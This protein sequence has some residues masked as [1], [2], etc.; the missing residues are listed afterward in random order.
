MAFAIEAQAKGDEDKIANGLR[1]LQEEDP[2]IDLHRDEATGEQIVAGLT[3]IHVEVVLGR[4]KERFGVEVNLKP[5]RVPYL[6]TIRQPAKAHAG[7]RSR[8]AGAGSSPTAISRSS[9]SRRRRLRVRQCDQGRRHPR[10]VHSGGRKGRAG[11]DGIRRGRGLPGPGR[12]REAV[13]REVP[14]GRLLEHAFKIA[15]SMAF[16]DAMQQAG[17][18]LLEPIMAVTLNVPEDA[19]GDVIGDLNS[20]R[21]RPL[22][23]EPKGHMTEIKA[24]VPMSEML[25]YAPDLR[26][27]TVGAPTTPW[28][29]PATRKFQGICRSRSSALQER[30]RRPSARR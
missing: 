26:A 14:S 2:T 16:K 22:G 1:Q 20:R 23:M 3:Q 15:G 29:S 18:V 7:T 12:A 13:R 19:V 5:P 30:N 21:G 10:R 6:E 25:T 17:A 24:E 9:R 4:L 27:I 11:G 28:T 8:P